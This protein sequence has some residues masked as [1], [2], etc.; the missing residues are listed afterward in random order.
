MR[1]TFLGAAG[2][3]TGSRTLVETDTARVLVDCGLFQGVKVLR[4]RNWTPFPVDPASLDA[5][6]LTHAHID[7]SGY[8]PALVRDGF[9]GPILTTPPTNDL[10]EIMLKDAAWLQEEEAGYA[11]RKGFSRHTPAKPLFTRQDAAAALAQFEP[12][13]AR[14]PQK[15]GDLSFELVPNGHIL[16]SAYLVLSEGGRKVVF[17]GDVG[18]PHDLLMRAP[19]PCPDAHTVVLESTYGDRD[20]GTEDPV[21]ALGVIAARTLARQGVLL[22]PS[23]AVGRAQAIVWA[24]HLLRVRGEIP[25][26]PIYV[27]SPMAQDASELY[28]IWS[29]QLRVGPAQV[30]DLFAVARFINSAEESKELNTRHGPMIIVSASGMLTGGRVI[31]HLKAFGGDPRNTILLPGFQAPGTRGAQLLDGATQLKIHGEYHPM[32]AEVARLDVFSAHADREELIAW[33][34]GGGCHPEQVLLNHGEPTSSDS[35]R[36]MLEERLGGRVEVVEQ[37][38]SF[39]V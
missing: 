34:T 2:T 33:L 21:D 30:Q 1:L 10:C 25:D 27:N 35:L 38:Q 13:P 6:I 32:R 15:V 39:E 19:A 9:A 31:H 20:H 24:L 23:F 29:D 36:L 5:V 26:V 14:T 22:I 12:V 18:R 4:N 11:N 3:V 16:G 17:S 28:R 37:S 7:H 8:L